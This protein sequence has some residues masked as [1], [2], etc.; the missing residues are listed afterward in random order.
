[1][2]SV[3]KGRP[4]LHVDDLHTWFYLR[5]GILKAVDGVTIEVGER[6]AVGLVGESGCGKSVT[7]FSVMGLVPVPG[8]IADGSISFGDRCIS[9]LSD[10][11]MSKIRGRDISMI[12]QDPM[13][14]LNPVFNVERQIMETILLHQPV[15]EQE[16][17]RRTVELL[18]STGIPEAEKV[19]KYYPHQLSGGMR[20]RVLIAMAIACNPALII[21]DEPTTALDVTVQAQILRLI[22]RMKEE[23]KTSL[24]LITHDLGIVA[25]MCDR[26]YVMYAGKIVEHGDVWQIFKHARHPYTRGLLEC[27]LS[28]DEFKKE[29]RTIDG[30]VPNLIHPP[31]G[32][33]F[34]T[35]CAFATA[36]CCNDPSLTQIEEGHYLAC[37]NPQGDK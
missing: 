23:L 32:C 4:T 9:T 16:A 18:R 7:A 17:R 19:A 20:Q 27:V 1:M 36:E 37:Y 26:V 3:K 21:A 14:Y 12:F 8:K 29:V 22:K 28:I 11:E 10:E 24:L 30:S 34:R 33:R 25:H 6:E 15:S 13:T 5:A 31:S 2:N 35:R